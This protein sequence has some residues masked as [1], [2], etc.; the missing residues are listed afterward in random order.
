MAEFV[1]NIRYKADIT[2]VSGKLERLSKEQAGLAGKTGSATSRMSASFGKFQTKITDVA[3]SMAKAGLAM[4]AMGVA[5]VA[6][7]GPKIL[8]M[9]AGL[10]ALDQKAKTVFSDGSLA[11]VEKWAS[12]T[13]SSMGMTQSEAIGVASS[14]GDL[15]KPMGF[16]A[17]QAAGMS[18]NIADL[19]G[20]LSAWSGGTQ[21]AAEV[22]DVLTKA[23]LGETDGLKSLGISISAAD[24]AAR[25]ASK[26]QN[27]LTGAALAQAE[28]VATQELILEKST[29]AQK[30]WA[31]G[32]MDAMKKQNQMKAALGTL[33]E[34]F[35][36]LLYPAVAKMVPILESL[37]T[38]L[39]EKIPVAVAAARTW[40]ESNLLPTFQRVVDFIEGNWRQAFDAL[41]GFFKTAFEGGKMMLEALAQAF[42][43]N[44]GTI[45]K[46]LGGIA[47]ALAGVALAWNLGPG[48]VITGVVAL[49]AGLLYAYKRFDWFK[50]GVDVIFKAIA[51]YIRT[52]V[53]VAKWAFT[54]VFAPAV[55][56]LWKAL[57][58]AWTK[59]KPIVDAIKTGVRL[60]ATGVRGYFDTIVK[61]AFNMLGTIVQGAWSVAKPIIDTIK[62]AIRLAFRAVKGYFNTILKPAFNLLG[63][64]VQGAWDVASPIVDTIQTTIETMASAVS[65]A[66]DAVVS[67]VKSGWNSVANTWNNSVGAMS[68]SIPSWIPG[69]WGS[70]DMPDLPTL[71]MGGR[72]PGIPGQEVVMK[73]VAGETVRT[74]GQENALRQGA[75]AGRQVMIGELHVHTTD[76]PRR[77]YDEALWR[78]SG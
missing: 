3:K 77:F 13:A 12:A 29:D 42:G 63:T 61:P 7:L 14:I 10:E 55:Q 50:K 1:E 72:V 34:T 73:L 24:I 41:I 18:T 74:T 6:V 25:V 62:S 59:A 45:L 32:S 39:S 60:L 58:S 16:T 49:V 54:E 46:V 76:Q 19:S 47:L 70:F 17:D 20:A 38:W 22:S 5:G 23:L 2:D 69:D 66:F 57:Q 27:E 9:G 51:T 67:A 28:A 75:G 33:K 36:K 71:H 30:A 44:Q 15:L 53:N 4:G 56:W 48:I 31:D 68:F 65:G 64:I 21:T 11:Q 8:Q 37:A 78:L 26:G 43:T 52:Y 35:V 40:F